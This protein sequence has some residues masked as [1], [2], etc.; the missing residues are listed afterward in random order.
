[1]K[2]FIS[3]SFTAF[4]FLFS[5]STFAQSAAQKFVVDGITVIM[6]PTVKDIINVSIYYKGGVTN[7]SEDQAGIEN[8]ALAGAPE[9]GTK[10]YSKDAFKDKADKFGISVSG[11][12]TYDY[13]VI[14]LNCISKYFNEGWDLLSAAVKNPTFN[15]NDY[16]LLKQKIL[17]GIKN[18]D[19]DPDSKVLKMAVENTFKGTSYATNPEGEINT[20]N[21]IS[22]RELKDY[23]FNTLLNKNRIFIVV[24]GKIS[25]QL[26]TNKIKRAL[27]NLPAKPYKKYEYHIP[28]IVANSLNIEPRQLA[29]NYIIGVMNAPLFT[30][31]DYAA[32]RLAV[33]AF[34]DNLFTEI[35]TKRNLSYAPYAV[36][37]RLKM[38]YNYMY[39][40]TTDP[41]ASAEVMVNEINRL[42][43]KGFSQKEFNAIRNLLITSNYMKEE[44][45]DAIAGSLG[46]S[47]ILGNWKM[48]EEF[49]G[50]IQKITPA[51]M[52]AVFKKYIKGIKWNY[53]G[54][55][56]QANE[57]KEAFDMKVE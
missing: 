45:T 27:G 57:A 14:S 52:T 33:S 36:P 53:L 1:M 5:Q 38:P 41:K 22:A 8:L 7:Y 44:S 15:E 21:N 48:D 12:S 49:I 20:V 24:V 39:V 51:D 40:S 23:Y 6:K 18:A 13:G 37:I 46:K 26:I 35:R 28:E 16:E 11:R 32:N 31:N 54:I 2:R 19:A 42:K 3:S 10:L 50:K 9:C 43:T 55:E 29:T 25:K 17:A 34:S 30:S 4:L 47:E 56:K